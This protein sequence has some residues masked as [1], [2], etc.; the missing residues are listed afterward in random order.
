MK[1]KKTGP[2]QG[3]LS[4]EKKETL[5]DLFLESGI[6]P[7]QA[8]AKTKIHY[9]T[10]K[11]YFEEFA[12]QLTDNESHEDWFAREK[13][14]RTR[15]LEGYSTNITTIRNRL[16]Q[17]NKLLDSS[18]TSNDHSLIDQYERIVRSE[19]TILIDLLDR[20][21]GLEMAAP[22]EVLLDKEIEIRIAL[23]NGV[24]PNE[25]PSFQVVAIL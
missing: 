3:T 14:V 6:T 25:T 5:K 7:Y 20:F 13:R 11:K 10:V 1:K 8:A 18:I 24:T 16:T 23:K 9:S 15:A 21:D 2:K 12:N 17:Y 4:K 19:T 22:T